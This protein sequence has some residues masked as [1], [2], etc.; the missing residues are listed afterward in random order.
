MRSHS[1][2]SVEA[3]GLARMPAH[4][5][6]VCAEMTSPDDSVMPSASTAATLTPQRDSTPSADSASSTM[7]WPCAPMEAPSGVLGSTM[8]IRSLPVMPALAS[9]A[10]ISAATSMPVKPAPT[11]TTVERDSEAVRLPSAARCASSL[12]AA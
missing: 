8:T 11:T 4:H 12:H 5:T 2:E 6:T 10:G 3:S 1:G 9:L 7:G